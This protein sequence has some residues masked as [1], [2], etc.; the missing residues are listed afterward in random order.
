MSDARKIIARN[1]K[2]FHL[3]EIFDR[4]EAGLCLKGTEVKSLRD[5]KVSLDGAFAHFR[6]NELY[7]FNL[8]IPP[9]MHGNIHN[10]DPKRPRKLLLRRRELRKLR[11]RVLERGFTLVPL[12]I[13]FK[14][15]WAKV[16]IALARGRSRADK[17]DRIKEREARREIRRFVR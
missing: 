12:S 3:Y 2:A 16:E 10:H 13:Y 15:G 4:Y 11:V 8:D 9:Y 5:G 14:R 6:G 1:R 17:K 7:L